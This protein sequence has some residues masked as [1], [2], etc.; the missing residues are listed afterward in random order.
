M[1][2]SQGPSTHDHAPVCRVFTQGR[3]GVGN[4]YPSSYKTREGG[5]TLLNPGRKQGVLTPC[6]VHALTPHTQTH[7][8]A[9]QHTQHVHMSWYIRGPH[10]S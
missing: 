3:V 5:K 7:T 10:A 1:G 2:K 4:R 8:H 6:E 9:P